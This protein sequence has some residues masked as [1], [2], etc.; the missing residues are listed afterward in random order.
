MGLWG[1][2]SLAVGTMIGASIF[3]I[4]GLGARIAG[5][6]LPLVFLI[7]GGA[8][9]FVAYS[10]ARLGSR[11]ISDAGPMEFIL[12]GIGDNLVTGALSF[13]FWFSY[14]V[15]IALFAKG[16]AGYLL[17]LLQLPAGILATGGAELAVILVFT[18]LGALGSTAVGRAESL[19][20]LIKLGILGVFVVLGI[21]SVQPAL[22]TPRLDGAGVHGILNAT[23]VFFLSYMGFGLV[24][25]A[26]ENMV[27]PARN[28]PRAIYLSILIVT[29]VY[30]AVAVTAVGNLPLPQ[31]IRA[32][33]N[34]LAVAA[35]PFLGNLGFQLIAIGA[36][37]SISSAIN[38][39]LFGGANV[40]Y[41]LARDGELPRLFERKSWFGSME[42]LYLTSGLGLLFALTFDLNGIASI[43]SSVYMV[44]YLFVLLS[45]LRLRGTCGGNPVIIVSGLLVILAIFVLLLLYQWQTNRH[46][47]YGTWV[48][49]GASLVIETI[50]RS[51]RGRGFIER[52]ISKWHHEPGV[53]EELLHR[54]RPA[55]RTKK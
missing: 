51:I 15:S 3:S 40:A 4:F 38:A 37:F 25:N 33:D 43:T 50:Y 18:L 28:V 9:L 35:R 42:G 20:V 21:W 5:S 1:A 24:T 19:I 2:V 55:D 52:E 53:L 44:I 32:E 34:A 45:H 31:L 26:S 17:P 14:V 27:D 48:T 49:I 30:I 54:K 36:L 11:I 13:L 39:T 8:A 29:L 47:F 46:A 7:S 41:A 16:F 6:N 10:Y 23:A 12:K 22:I